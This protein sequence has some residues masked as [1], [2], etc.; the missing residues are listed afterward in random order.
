VSVMPQGGLLRAGLRTEQFVGAL[1][2]HR[3]ACASCRGW[4]CR[5]SLEVDLVYCL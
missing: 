5:A 3:V 2:P 1:L 4:C